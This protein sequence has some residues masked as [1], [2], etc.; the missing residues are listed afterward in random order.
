MK[1]FFHPQSKSFQYT[2][3]GLTYVIYQWVF[4]FQHH[5]YGMVLSSLA[6][7]PVMIAS[8]YLG[9]GGGIILALI[10]IGSDIGSLLAL[11]HPVQEL[12]EGA[13]YF[14]GN[15]ILI[16]VAIIVGR[17]ATILR[18]RDE[19]IQKL[20]QYEEARTAR[21]DF[22][23]LLNAITT[24]ALEAESLQSTLTILTEKITK[25]FKA[26]DGFFALWD[27]DQAV[28]IPTVAYGSMS[29]VYPYFSFKPN[30]RTLGN[31]VI[32]EGY[33]IP[34]FDLDH[35]P[36]IDPDIASL[37][38]S[39]SMLGIPLIAQGR[40][41]GVLLLGYVQKHPFSQAEVIQAGVTGEQLALV[42]SKMLLL[43]EERKQVKQL[44]TLHDVA[45]ISVEADTEDQLIERVTDVIGQ[46]LFPDN[47]GI[48]LLDEKAG[49]LH[50]HPSYRFYAMDKVELQ[51]LR[52]GEGIS[53]VVARDGKTLRFGDVRTNPH[54]LDMDDRTISELCVPIKIK[55]RVLGVINAESTKRNAFTVDDE[56]L[57]TTLAGQLAT[58]I[59][60]T[61]KTQAERKWLDQL[62]HSNDLIYA[63][64]Q[65]TTHIERALTIDDIIQTLGQ[66]LR[67]IGLTCIMALHN[68][69]RALFHINYT[70]LEP[71]LLEIIETGLGYPLINHTF[72]R[73]RLVQALGARDILQPA[74]IPNPADE[75]QILFT[76][77]ERPGVLRILGEIG[78]TPEMEPLRLSLVFEENLLGILWVWGGG[79]RNS[80]IPILS[81]FAKQIGISLERA[82]LF[83]EVQSLALTDPLTGLSNRRSLFEL[84]KIEFSR[85]HRMNRPFCCMMLDLD[86]FKQVNDKYGHQVGDEVL[87]EFAR[88]CKC[89]V[90][91]IDLVGRYGGEEIII[92]LPETDLKTGLQVAERLRKSIAETPIT[93]AGHELTLTTSI[94]VAHLDENTLQLNTLVARADQA[95]YIAKH[96]GR[97]RVAVS[98]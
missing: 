45:L 64:A 40:K 52:L 17:M 66:E 20:K 87:Q 32:K 22:L 70:S 76:E 29:D 8:W 86:H 85:A 84:G 65:I 83:A 75:I 69:E 19:A 46:N 23:E 11:G 57:L 98:K 3:I 15:I 42:L 48:L 63:I 92:L 5:T 30:E 53:G 34:V 81:I 4:A 59:E 55:E 47:F 74:A 35:S 71:H 90:R 91:E 37:Y 97:N 27:E 2:I 28:N 16:V 60:Q 1:E 25:L 12:F 26:D 89:S 56:R 94:G 7:F 31:S 9:A 58:A 38:P 68:P 43:E 95:L 79:I 72:S 36:H 10:S 88:R 61:R 18:E 93:V 62:A 77:T 49:V 54:Y 78:V 24:Q 44:T 33:A 82:R 41:L 51:T 39:R 14:I 80:D 67:N 73:D 96:K 50:P 6:I 21:T 13:G